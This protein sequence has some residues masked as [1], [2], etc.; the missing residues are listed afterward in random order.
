MSHRKYQPKILV[1]HIA[2]EVHVTKG[3]KSDFMTLTWE[4]D[5]PC[6]VIARTTVSGIHD[7]GNLDN[8]DTL[9][10]C[11]NGYRDRHGTWKSMPRFRTS[12]ANFSDC[13]GVAFMVAQK[14]DL[15]VYVNLEAS[16]YVDFADLGDRTSTVTLSQPTFTEVS[17]A[18]MKAWGLGTRLYE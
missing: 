4:E 3:D 2:D 13:T 7:Q 14:E 17:E 5:Q 6:Y 9:C 8:W 16:L 18:Q 10:T 15:S 1:T 11:V 12:S